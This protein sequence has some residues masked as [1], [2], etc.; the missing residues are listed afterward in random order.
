MKVRMDKIRILIVD[1]HEIIYRGIKDL[2]QNEVEYK[3]EDYAVNGKE[4]IV[5][6]RQIIP[7]IIFMDISMPEMNGIEAIKV[8][9]AELSDTKLIVLTQHD[10]GEIILQ[11]MK[12]GAHGYLLKNSTKEQFIFAMQQVLSGKRYL[13]DET[14][15][16]MID[17]TLNKFEQERSENEIYLTRREKE[18]IR[19]IYEDKSNHQIA[20]DLNISLRTVETH[21]RN[22]MQKLKVTTVIGLLKIAAKL[23]LITLK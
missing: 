18:I 4:A 12:A 3:I 11:A 22:I 14:S 16:K 9:S 23:N 7:D 15:R 6:A 2:L 1:D 13:N 19:K 21:R 5:K 20:E 10:E 8:L 17:L